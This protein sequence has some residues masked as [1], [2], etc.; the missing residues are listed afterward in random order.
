[1]LKVTQ[2]ESTRV[3]IQTQVSVL[4]DSALP[5]QPRQ[6]ESLGFWGPPSAMVSMQGGEWQQ[7]SLLASSLLPSMALLFPSGSICFGKARPGCPSGSI[8][9]GAIF[10]VPAQPG[11]H[12]FMGWGRGLAWRIRKS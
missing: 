8:L 9:E 7:A 2:R 5:M 10:P 11:R 1:M 6:R 12:D 3:G 4:P